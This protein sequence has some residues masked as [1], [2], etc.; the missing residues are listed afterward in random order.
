MI[1]AIPNTLTI[2]RILLTPIFA[3]Y[4]VQENVFDMQLAT[5]LYFLASFTDWLDG[6]IARRMN[7]TTQFGQ[8]L[9]PVADKI[10]VSTALVLFA[11]KGYIYTWMVFIII[12][13][14]ILI[15]ALRIYASYYGKVIITS[16]FGK[17]KTFIQMGFVFVILIYLNIPELPSI[18]LSYTWGDWLM[19]P[20]IAAALVTV[21]T[22]ASGIHYLIHN[23]SHIFEIYR[24]ST[25]K[26]T[27]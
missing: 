20:T 14:D 16:S 15:T 26:L 21:L 3:Y 4:F 23:R 5:L 22:F 8:F 7:Y 6:I 17:W 12:L 19:W 13:R 1:Y 24:R 2:S 25:R 10:L 11:Y 18:K 9:D 27:H